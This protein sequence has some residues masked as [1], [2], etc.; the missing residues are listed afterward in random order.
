[1]SRC[2]EK[3]AKTVEEAVQLA[4]TELGLDRENVKIEVLEE[5]SRGLFGL[6][7]KDAVVKVSSNINLENAHRS[8]W[9]T[10]FFPWDFA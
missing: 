8:S 4:L 10:C 9:M 6:G 7:A 1:M 5:G 2:V 3:S